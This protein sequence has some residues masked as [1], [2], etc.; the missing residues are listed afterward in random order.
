M[1]KTKTVELIKVEKE[2]KHVMSMFVRCNTTYS[3]TAVAMVVN[4][5]WSDIIGPIKNK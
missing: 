2:F 4:G 3:P 1:G 5:L